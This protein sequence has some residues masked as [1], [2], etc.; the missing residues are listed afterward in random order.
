M[1]NQQISTTYK[2]TTS[3]GL[4][5]LL[6]IHLCRYSR[7][8]ADV[9]ATKVYPTLSCVLSWLSSFT[10]YNLEEFSIAAIII[11][12]LSIVVI[13]IKRRW[14]LW[15]CL[16]YEATIILWT[17]LWFYVGWCTNYTRSNIYERTG[18][19]FTEYD[20]TRFLNFAHQFVKDINEVWTLVPLNSKYVDYTYDLPLLESEIKAFYASVPAHYG[21]AKP[22]SWQHPKQIICNRLYSYV[23]V[24]GYMAPLFSESCLN[25][26]ILPF[27][28]PFT[29]A[30]EY[31]HILGVSNEAEA[32]WWAF[33]A[34]AKS[35][36]PRVRYSAYK[37]I[38]QHIL[39]NARTLLNEQQ[40]KTLQSNLR[41]EV[42]KDLETTRKHWK[43][44]RSPKLDEIQSKIYDSFLKSNDVK[45]GLQNY[46]QVVGLLVN[47]KYDET[48]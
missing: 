25:A 14:R 12:A 26:D 4:T 41:Q 46:S 32:N 42:V 24:L 29:Y 19:K 13:G 31:A 39:F 11:A 28:Y 16:R 7:A 5:L 48:E 40:Y 10:R 20:E 33:H 2:L 3:I 47:I 9:Y 8:M 27:D 6:L 35:E 23:G 37:G 38:V 44:L 22:R 21:L 15:R 30:H 18:T 17:Y 1:N 34:C 43:A 45:A 36:N